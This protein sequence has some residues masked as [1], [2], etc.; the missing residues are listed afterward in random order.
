MK[1]ENLKL[2][3]DY[4]E[5]VPPEMFDMRTFRDRGFETEIKCN[6]VGCVIGHC[7][8]LGPEFV[9][10][11]CGKIEFMFWSIRFTGLHYQQD[12]WKWC[13]D[14]NWDEFDNTP[15]GAA[16]RIRW[17]IANGLP[18]NWEEQMN[19]IDPLCY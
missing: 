15:T 17:L 11:T 14:S 12:Q 18:E 16:K 10:I 2:M 5:T 19:G 6:S 1:I 8:H 7:V 13:F 9:I 3:A 4:I